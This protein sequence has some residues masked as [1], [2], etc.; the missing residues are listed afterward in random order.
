MHNLIQPLF[1][2]SLFV[3]VRAGDL[4]ITAAI[5]R[6]YLRAILYGITA[7]LALAAVI[8]TLFGL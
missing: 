2:V 1:V 3:C 6:D 4:A 7:I 5:G 8:V